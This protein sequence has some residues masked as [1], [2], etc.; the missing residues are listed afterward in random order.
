MMLPLSAVNLPAFLY[1]GV[2][3][4]AIAKQQLI[5]LSICL[6]GSKDFSRNFTFSYYS[7]YL[8]HTKSNNLF[9]RVPQY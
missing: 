5:Y 2:D 4:K 9:S 1:S 8:S 7:S 3:M 6:A